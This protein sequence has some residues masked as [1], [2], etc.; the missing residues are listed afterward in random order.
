MSSSELRGTGSET[1]LS[2]LHGKHRFPWPPAHRAH[3]A[4]D[5]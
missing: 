1:R 4:S 5:L 2:A 3:T